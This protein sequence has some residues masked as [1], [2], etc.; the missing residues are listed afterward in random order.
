MPYVHDLFVGL[1]IALVGLVVLLLWRVRGVLA[2]LETR[3]PGTWVELGKPTLV[4]NN[5]LAN[6]LT[7]LRFLIR[8]QFRGLNDPQLE[9]SCR[10]LL[11]LYGLGFALFFA[12]LLLL[13]FIGPQQP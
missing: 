2:H 11:F 1:W 4:W 3:H 6:N 10:F 9:A 8:R 12:V 13:P 5:S 7:F